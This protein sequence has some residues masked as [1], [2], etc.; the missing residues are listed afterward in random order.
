MRQ[1]WL[2]QVHGLGDERLALALEAW[3]LGRLACL[4]GLSPRARVLLCLAMYKNGS[5][6]SVSGTTEECVVGDDSF[7]AVVVGEH[8]AE[9]EGFKFSLRV[10]FLS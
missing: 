6:S 3:S 9:E 2:V 5:S 10:A 4:D 7:D 8:M 1:L